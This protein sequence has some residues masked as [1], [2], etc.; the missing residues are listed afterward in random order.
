ME[1]SSKTGGIL[2]ESWGEFCKRESR[3]DFRESW[4]ELGSF[5]LATAQ[6]A[7]LELSQVSDVLSDMDLSYHLDS[8]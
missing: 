2:G 4:G 3:G 7:R 6:R 1:E 5:I 8:H